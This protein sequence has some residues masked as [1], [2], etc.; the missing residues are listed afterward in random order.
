MNVHKSVASVHEPIESQCR[1]RTARG[2]DH[3]PEPTAE[4]RLPLF[5]DACEA[6]RYRSRTASEDDTGEA[7]AGRYE[8]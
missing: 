8:T 5:A 3:E 6:Y 7:G 1:L 4:A 2:S